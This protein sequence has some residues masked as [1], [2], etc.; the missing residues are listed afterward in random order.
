VP[1]RTTRAGSPDPSLA[2]LQHLFV[3]PAW[4]GT[5]LGPALLAAAVQAADDRGF[6]RMRLFTP[7]GQAR[8][9]RFYE[10]E[11]WRPAGPARFDPSFGLPLVEYRR[12]LRS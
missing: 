1:A 7:A 10:R 11:G 3:R 12:T 9:R 8:G 4:W 6:S 5:G 2:H